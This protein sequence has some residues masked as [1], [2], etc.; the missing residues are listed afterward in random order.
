MKQ[1]PTI[2][3]DEQTVL[4]LIQAHIER[5]LSGGA[6]R[7]LRRQTLA[8]ISTVSAEEGGE[9]LGMSPRAFKGWCKRMN[10][11][12]LGLGYKTPRWSVGAIAEKM[13]Q[14]AIKPKAGS[15]VARFLDENERKT[16]A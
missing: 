15:R 10:I 16:A 4:G 6:L 12:V 9:C 7:R 14:R 3:I 5:V 8:Q 2:A 11:P 13:N 1:L